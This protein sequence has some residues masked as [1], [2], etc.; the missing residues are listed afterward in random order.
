MKLKLEQL[1]AHLTQPPAALY[2]V[3]GDE[4]L[5]ILEAS[6]AIRH[7]A[8][9]QGC[10]E[11]DVFTVD[12]GFD[13]A[14]FTTTLASG[15]LFSQRRLVELRLNDAKPGDVGGKALMQYAAAPN[16]DR[17]VLISAGRLDSSTQKTRWFTALEAAGVVIQT[18][19]LTA[20]QLS[21]WLEQRLHRQ[22]LKAT[23]DALALLIERVEGNLLAA[24][25]EIDK[26]A[27]QYA[28]STLDVATVLSNLE[29][30]ANYTV[31]ELV[32]AALLGD[33]ERVL[34]IHHTLQEEDTELVLIAWALAR[35]VQLLGQLH[36]ELAHGKS[37][38]AAFGQYKIWDQ[39]KPLMQSAL[40][41]L[42]RRD[43]RDMLM[44]CAALD[45]CIKGVSEDD[46][47]M[48]LQR[49]LLRLAGYR[50][51]HIELGF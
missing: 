50:Q 15:S 6:D 12:P 28:G 38:A 27:L 9:Q 20:Q 21:R 13:W 51:V 8:R 39:R 32:D 34:R 4:P 41:R 5:H 31:F 25:Q 14:A 1:E 2:L 46:P 10:T 45:R 40:Q 18:R 33:G 7:A 24:A 3:F 36:A 44:G 43:C 49:L 37:L 47:W 48:L 35:E 30:H 42:N 26:L 23:P 17:V 11:R 19:P 22:G 29:H 16:P